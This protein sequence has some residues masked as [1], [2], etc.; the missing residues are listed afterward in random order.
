MNQD[1]LVLNASW[2]PIGTVNWQDAF[3]KVF[4]GRA[5]VAEHYDEIIRTPGDSYLK[6]AVIVCTEY[7]K[8]PRQRTL[9]S[10]RMVFVRDNYTCQYCSRKLRVSEAT[11]DHVVPTSKGGRSTFKNT[12][13]ACESC[14]M[15]KGDKSLKG[16]G[17]KLLRE[18]K[19]P[20]VN[21]TKMKFYKKTIAP[22]WEMH[23]KHYIKEEE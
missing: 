18:P 20:K 14:N 1:C 5:Y 17:L 13:C 22:E 15:K 10:K 9:Y 19:R 16:C 11:L 7:N 2:I 21:P 8:L 23:L 4:N 3:T 12:V 6:P